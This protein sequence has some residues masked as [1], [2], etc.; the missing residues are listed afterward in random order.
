MKHPHQPTPTS[1]WLLPTPREWHD[2]R[3]EVS[4]QLGF[5]GGRKTWKFLFCKSWLVGILKS[6]ICFGYL[7][8]PPPPKKMP[9][10]KLQQLPN[11]AIFFPTV[12]I[13]PIKVFRG[14]S[15]LKSIFQESSHIPIGSMYGIFTY[16]WL[17]FMINVGKYT[18][19][20]SYGIGRI[21]KKNT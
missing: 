14:N 10:T 6:G 8:T 9:G 13:K 17:K 21:L 16:I 12:W 1:T 5:C 15:K 20:W 7:G 4:L 18:I 19:H 3:Q 11:C 2:L